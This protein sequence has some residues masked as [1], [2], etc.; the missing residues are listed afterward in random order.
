[1]SEKFDPE[2]KAQR[3]AQRNQYKIKLT[4][5][6]VM[7]LNYTYVHFKFKMSLLYTVLL[8]RQLSIIFLR[9]MCIFLKYKLL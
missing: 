2:R 6:N 8:L 9:R 1:M 4:L 3:K 7:V 5:Q